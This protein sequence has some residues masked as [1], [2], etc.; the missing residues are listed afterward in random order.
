MQYFPP[1]GNGP[2]SPARDHALTSSVRFRYL[3]TK[4]HDCG[5]RVL[6]EFLAAIAFR[7][8]DLPLFG[9]LEAYAEIDAEHLRQVGSDRWPQVVHLVPASVM[10]NDIASGVATVVTIMQ[11]S[12]APRRPDPDGGHAA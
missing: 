7:Q 2:A 9:M 5:P 11:K 10:Q 1:A 8:P 3:T 4:L 12:L 6:G